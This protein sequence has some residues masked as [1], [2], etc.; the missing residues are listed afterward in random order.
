MGASLCHVLRSSVMEMPW[1]AARW[2]EHR[3]TS[4]PGVALPG[5]QQEKDLGPAPWGR[6]S[7][8]SHAESGGGSFQPGTALWRFGQIPEQ[9]A[10]PSCA[11]HPTRM[12]RGITNCVV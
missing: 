3:S 4:R 8:P 12:N 10:R 1:D 6:C 7:A 9:R 5:H 2:K 11:Q